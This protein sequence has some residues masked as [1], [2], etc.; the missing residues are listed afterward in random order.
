MKS[1]CLFGGSFDPVHLGHLLVARAALEELPVERVVFIPAALSPFKT[2]QQ[3]TPAPL[4][5]QM[6]RTSL[7]G[8]PW[9]GVDEQE[10]CRG[11]VSY[12]ID[13]IRWYKAN[14]PE[15]RLFYLIGQDNAPLLPEWREPDELAASAEFV[16][17]PRPATGARTFL[18]AHHSSPAPTKMPYR[19]VRAPEQAG[20]V[21]APVHP[22]KLRSLNGF[23]LGVSSSEIRAR[24]QQGLPVED[25]LPHG[26]G[27]IIRNNRLYL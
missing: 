19:N 5:L 4:R 10:I 26:V 15:A 25:L 27:E 8:R 22:F 14:F 17:I 16:V 13:T 23:P 24:V 1:I 6:L 11:G 18:S 21:A 12:T 9:A 20:G 7:A 3:P 2:Q